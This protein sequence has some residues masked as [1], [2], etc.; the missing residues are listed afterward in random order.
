MLTTEAIRWTVSVRAKLRYGVN[1][2]R[3][4]DSDTF[5]SGQR[6][7]QLAVHLGA[8]RILLLGYDCSLAFGTHWHGEHTD[9]LKN[10]D[11][12][13]LERWHQEFGRL[14]AALPDTD[15]INCSRHSALT[16]FPRG[17]IEDIL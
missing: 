17:N 12:A 14:V 11:P 1:L 7:I 9:G 3:P 5:N 2:F 16:C 4:G 8:K 13:S 15:I 10:P 6:A